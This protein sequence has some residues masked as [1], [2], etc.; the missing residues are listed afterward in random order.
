MAAGTIPARFF[1]QGRARPD[2]PGYYVRRGDPWLRVSWGRYV[3][4]VRQVARALIDLGL[5]PGDRVC[6]LGFN[7][8]EWVEMALGCMAVGVIPAGIYTGHAPAAIAHILRHSR[9]RALLLEDL[10]YWPKLE[11]TGD[12]LAGLEHIVLMRATAL[13]ESSETRDDAA[14]DPGGPGADPRL[15]SWEAFLARGDAVPDSAIDVRGRD[16]AED[17]L[18]A[19]VYTPGTSGPPKAVML[20]HRNL[21]W[22]AQ[23]AA[24]LIAV[25]PDDSSL[26]YLPLS[27]I[28]E[29]LFSIYLPAI[30]G[31]A[32]YFADSLGRVA[33]SLKEVQPSV[34]FGESRIW[35]AFRARLESLLSRASGP[36][37]R[38]LSWAISVT[39]R[40]NALEREDKP[41]SRLLAAQRQL[42]RR[43]ALDR[44]RRAIGLGRARICISGGAP[45]DP[46]ALEFFAG[47]DILIQEAYGQTE[48]C[49]TT[50]FNRDGEGA[51]KRLLF[52][53]AGKSLPGV[54][55]R[56]ADDGELLVKGP[57]VFLGYDGDDDATRAHLVDGWLH[58]GDLGTIDEHGFVSI[59]CRKRDLI[60]TR[61]GVTTSPRVPELALGRHELVEEAIVVGHGR[62]YLA[63]LIVVNKPAAKRLVDGQAL[64][65]RSPQVREAI[66]A[67][68]AAYNETREPGE[69]IRRFELLARDLTVEDG[70]LTPS[71]GLRRAVI[72]QRFADAIE[73]MYRDPDEP[74]AP[75]VAVQA[76][77]Q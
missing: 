55:L 72:H 25:H 18:A 26:S 13:P 8:P 16:I 29:Q 38:I 77:P 59:T 34:V 74:P 37:K 69:H 46:E 4:N 30:T 61:A 67:H 52:G 48:G 33:F 41:V 20:S 66:A 6:L 15:L 22:T 53:T 35:E 49:G 14:R 73:S 32:V 3:E 58:T 10:R 40:A 56:L 17:D 60:T 24:E 76:E 12:A 68:I 43:L 51:A 50:T 28:S 5:R 36:R 42:A 70:E 71:L 65:H 1:A 19:L 7:R 54:E 64:P 2:A 23:T 11:R 31:S 47:L 21:A 63:A 9:A 45:L 27:H 57:N 75:R 44:L 39:R 62:D